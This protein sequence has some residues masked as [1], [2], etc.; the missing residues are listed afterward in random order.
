MRYI[1][2]ALVSLLVLFD[3]ADATFIRLGFLPGSA[4]FPDSFAHD[5]S[6]NGRMAVGSSSSAASAP[7]GKEAFKWT[8]GGGFGSVPVFDT[9]EGLGDLL[10]ALV[11]SL[12]IVE[13]RAYPPMALLSLARAHRGSRG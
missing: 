8:A 13:Q 3:P 7:T 4:M 1:I 10:G 12:S 9:L 11:L 5:V 2:K 6:A